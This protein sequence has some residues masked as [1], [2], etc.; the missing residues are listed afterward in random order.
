MNVIWYTLIYHADSG[1]SIPLFVWNFNLIPDFFRHINSEVIGNI[2]MFL[3]FGV[4]YPLSHHHTTFAKTLMT[5]LIYVVMI[6]LVQPIFG[7]A[8]DINDIILNTLGIPASSAVYFFAAKL[9][10]S[11]N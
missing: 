5:G 7:R 6:E 2:A 1:H 3:P 10:S 4:L 9:V 11:K 8:F